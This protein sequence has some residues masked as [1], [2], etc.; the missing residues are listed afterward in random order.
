MTEKL[1]I[2]DTDVRTALSNLTRQLYRKQSNF[3][4]VAGIARG[5]LIPATMLSHYMGLPL[6]TVNYSRLDAKMSNDQADDAVAGIVRLLNKGE[7]VLLV[8]DICDEG[9]TMNDLCDAIERLS[10]E[11]AGQLKTFVLV[12]NEACKTFTP[13]FS[14]IDINKE[15]NPSWIVFPW[16]NWWE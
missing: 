16:E 2:T 15:E 5:G 10:P 14:G 13:D 1:Y 11:M 7:R 4:Y 6:L 9:H 8:D 12:H 3:S